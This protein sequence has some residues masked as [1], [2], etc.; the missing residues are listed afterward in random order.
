MKTFNTTIGK[1]Y[2]IEQSIIKAGVM[3]MEFSRKGSFSIARNM[4]KFTDELDEYKRQRSELIKQYSGG[5]DSINPDH[6]NWKEFVKEYT[7]LSSVDVSIDI[8]TIV[9]DDLPEQATPFVC[10]LL[11]FMIEEMDV[12]KTKED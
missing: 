5:E 4:K 11:D 12:E 10:T 6:E 8:N 3:T 1:L 2:D 9:E 7:L